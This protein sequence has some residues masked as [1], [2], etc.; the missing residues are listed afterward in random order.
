V[1]FYIVYDVHGV[2]AMLRPAGSIRVI[3]R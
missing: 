3:Q 2:L 1:N